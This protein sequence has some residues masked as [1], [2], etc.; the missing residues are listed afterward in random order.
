MIKGPNKGLPSPGHVS[1]TC[2]TEH[3]TQK[4]VIKMDQCADMAEARALPWEAFGHVL[5]GTSDSKV[6]IL[7]SVPTTDMGE[8]E[9]C[10]WMMLTAASDL[11]Q[12]MACPTWKM[13]EKGYCRTTG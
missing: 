2:V 10:K 7:C 5:K 4:K 1:V 8:S 11:Q 13:A 3:V 12:A 6:I 9:G